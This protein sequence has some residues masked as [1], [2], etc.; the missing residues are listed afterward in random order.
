MEIQ[1]DQQKS[2]KAELKK[3]RTLILTKD[4]INL[5]LYTIG[6]GIVGSDLFAATMYGAQTVTNI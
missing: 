5:I 2:K 4:K 3:N 6:G 1:T